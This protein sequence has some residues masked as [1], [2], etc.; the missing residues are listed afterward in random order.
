MGDPRA[1]GLIN[2]LDTQPLSEIC[3]D[4]ELIPPEELPAIFTVGVS[5][6]NIQSDNLARRMEDIRAGS[7]G[8]S[9]TGFTINTQSA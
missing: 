6:A 5:L 8:F 4:L 7:S 2:F 9:A 1:S 3:G